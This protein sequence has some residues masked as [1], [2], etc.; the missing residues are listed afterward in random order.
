MNRDFLGKGIGFPVRTNGSGGV[1]MS[2]Y[3]RDIEESVRLVIG[4]AFGERVMRPDFGCG[5][6]DLVFAPNNPATRH[7]VAHHVK[8]AL[9][10]WEPRILGVDVK[11]ATDPQNPA[12]ILVDL[13]YQ[14]RA[15]NSKFNLVYPFYLEK[16]EG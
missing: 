14:V 5:I 8:E 4:T 11:V 3:E 9:Y 15:T 10:K 13:S 7:L 2:A 1:V 16:T 6:H 12:V